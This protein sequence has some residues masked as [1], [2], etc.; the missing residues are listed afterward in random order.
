M[1]LN[2]FIQLSS[3]LMCVILPPTCILCGNLTR[4]S[5]NIC[6]PCELDLPMLSHHCLQCAQFLR[7]TTEN[8]RCGFCLKTP[9]AFDY[10]H[11]L[12]PYVPPITQLIVKL[13]F[14]A[15]LNHARALSELLI[16]RIPVW[17]REKTL[18]DVIVPVPL[19]VKR[20]RERGFNQALELARPAAKAFGIPLDINGVVRSK[21]TSAQ[22]GL[23]AEER[24]KNIA[25]AFT[26]QGDYRGLTVAM[27]DDVITTG[28]TIRSIA[29]VIK[30]QGA[31][32][33][34]VWC[35]A[36]RGEAM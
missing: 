20:M 23:L 34:D 18:P 4:R 11:A 8:I 36:R 30:K 32:R 27:V 16:E 14:Q 5:R 19:H 9:P 15:K 28:H 35:I 1:F 12:F 13:K 21:Y 31:A 26:A 24:K 2:K 17:Y 3:R 7:V 33:I 6:L 22:S 10:T 29:T 25:H